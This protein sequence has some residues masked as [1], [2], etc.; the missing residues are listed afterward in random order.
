MKEQENKQEREVYG[1]QRG[2]CDERLFFSEENMRG[3]GV[4]ERHL[5]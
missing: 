2:T 1:R 3:G 4:G 5:R